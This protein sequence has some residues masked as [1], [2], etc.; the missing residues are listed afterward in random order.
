MN[1]QEFEKF[2][3]D[4]APLVKDELL[5][6]ETYLKSPIDDDGLSLR[7]NAIAKKVLQLDPRPAWCMRVLGEVLF[8]WSFSPELR[9]VILDE[10]SDELCLLKNS[11]LF[12]DG[13]VSIIQTDEDERYKQLLY[14]L[15]SG[16]SCDSPKDHERLLKAGMAVD[17][18]NLSLDKLRDIKYDSSET[19]VLNRWYYY[20][21]LAE[22]KNTGL[23][24]P[25]TTYLD[26]MFDFEDRKYITKC[27]FTSRTDVVL[28]DNTLLEVLTIS[29]MY[30]YRSPGMYFIIENENQDKPDSTYQDYCL[31]FRYNLL[32]E[33]IESCIK[34]G[35]LVE[36][37][38]SFTCGHYIKGQKEFN[39][40]DDS[41]FCFSALIP[42]FS[43]LEFEYHR[44]KKFNGS[45]I[46]GAS[47]FE[48]KFD[49]PLFSSKNL[50]SYLN[51]FKNCNT[52]PITCSVFIPTYDDQCRDIL[53]SVLSEEVVEQYIIHHA[54]EEDI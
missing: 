4:Y 9:Y 23:I 27:L 26:D 29:R 38:V 12:K 47:G 32:D 21:L 49:N 16:T 36:Q 39:L 30:Y 46:I 8:D 19:G 33:D 3:R 22:I 37:D 41:F 31:K 24:T 15:V 45:N 43:N 34:E 53:N 48:F 5:D 50:H 14:N 11:E 52:N 44:L 35:T 40:A 7:L 18:W 6:L 20:N 2:K 51:V 28:C 10:F 25:E 13:C 1:I 17:I 42:K 54:Y